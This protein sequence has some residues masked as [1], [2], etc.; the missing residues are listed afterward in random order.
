VFNVFLGGPKSSI[1]ENVI[2]INDHV[3][4]VH[5]DVRLNEFRS[6][7]SIKRLKRALQGLT[8]DFCIIDTAPTYDNIVGN[9]LMASDILL[10]PVQQDVFSCDKGKQPV[11]HKAVQKHFFRALKA[12]GISEKERKERHLSFHSWLYD[13]ATKWEQLPRSTRNCGFGGCRT[14]WSKRSR[15]TAPIG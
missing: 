9:V 2:V 8:Y 13:A 12:I 5:G 15:A 4:L 11:D 6:T 10:V 1:A 14:A 3:D 7:D